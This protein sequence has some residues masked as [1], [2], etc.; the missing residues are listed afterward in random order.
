MGENGEEKKYCEHLHHEQ[1]P[2]SHQCTALMIANN[3]RHITQR[4]CWWFPPV[5]NSTRSHITFAHYLLG[6]LEK[7]HSCHFIGCSSTEDLHWGT[8]FFTCIFFKRTNKHALQMSNKVLSVRCTSL[9]ARYG[10]RFSIRDT[11]FL[12]LQSTFATKGLPC[13]NKNR[14]NRFLMKSSLMVPTYDHLF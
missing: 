1:N 11:Y 9:H 8:G 7:H 2:N 4:R 6:M 13:R 10:R 12:Y 14:I 3:M 5:T